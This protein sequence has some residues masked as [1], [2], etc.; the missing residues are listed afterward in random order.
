MRNPQMMRMRALGVVFLTFS[1]LL[2]AGIVRA[3]DD[4]DDDRDQDRR[5]RHHDRDDRNRD[6]QDEADRDTSMLRGGE[7]SFLIGGFAPRG[8][9]DQWDFNE[10]FTTQDTTDFDDAIGGVGFAT[11][12]NPY[13]DIGLQVEYY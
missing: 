2:T 8:N 1:V 12:V 4:D 6:D 3:D 13:F 7:V 11:H 5:P 10:K 9:S